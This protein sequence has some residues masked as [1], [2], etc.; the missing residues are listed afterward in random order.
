MILLVAIIATTLGMPVVVFAIISDTISAAF[1][2]GIFSIVNTY[3]N[4]RMLR[5]IGAT[6]RSA[7]AG[8]KALLELA[9]DQQE[10]KE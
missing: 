1:V 10:K 8:S 2:A 5:Q 6:R 3:L 4:V 9:K 7:R